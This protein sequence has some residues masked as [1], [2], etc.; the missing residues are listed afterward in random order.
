MVNSEQLKKKIDELQKECVHLQNKRDDPEGTAEDFTLEVFE[1]LGWKRRS[2]EVIRQKNVKQGPHTTRVDYSFKRENDI[3][4]SFYVE[5]KRFSDKL[6]NPEHIK[7]ALQYGKNSSTR[8]VILTNF[9]K[10]RVFNSD[11]FNE[12]DHAELFKEFTIEEVLSNEECLKWLLL[13][14]RENGECALN[15]YAKNHKKWKDSADIKEL[16]TKSLLDTRKKLCKAIF[17]QNKMKFD[18]GQDAEMEVDKCVQHIFDRIIFCRMLEDN[19]IDPNLRIKNVFDQWEEGDKRM[20]FYKDCLCPFFLKMHEKYDSTI[21]DQERIDRLS[22]KNEDFIEIFKQFYKHSNGLHYNFGAIGVDVLGHTYESYLEYNVKKT[23]K[24]TDVVEG[25]YVRKQSGIYYTPE[26][27][28]DYLVRETLGKKLAKCKTIKEALEVRVLDP[29]CGS[30]T[31]LVRAYEEFRRWLINCAKKNGA[32]DLPNQIRLNADSENGVSSFLDDVLENCIYGIDRDPRAT[33]LARLNLFLR[34]VQNPKKLP[35]L[36]I[37]ERDSL[38]S[39]KEVKN[40]FIFERDFPLVYEKGGFDVVIGNPPWEKWKPD[41]QEFFEERDPGFKSLPTQEAKKRMNELMRK[42]PYLKKEWNE[43]LAEYEAYST[44]YRENYKFQSAEAGGKMVSG[45]MDLYKIFTEQAYNLAK[46]G[47]Y[48]GFV[49]PSSIYTDLGAK[50]LRKMLFDKCNVLGLFSFENR[51]KAIFPDVHSSYKPVLL[52]FMKGSITSSFPC[53]FFLHSK[54]DLENALKKPTILTSDFV[55]KSSPTSWNILEIKSR[56]DF[57]IVQKLLKHTQLRDEIK[58]SWNI[59]TQSGFHMTNDSHLFHEGRLGGIPMLEG[60]NI[61]QFTHQWKE[62]PQAR[63]SIDEKDIYASLKDD[64]IYHKGYWLAYRLIASSTN[65]RTLIST[66]IPQGYVCGNSIAIVK[67][68]GLKNLC[69]LAGILNSFIVD[70]F[71]RQKVS[72]NVNMFYFLEIPI[73]R[74][75]SGP[76]YESIARMT[77][78][79]VSVTDEFTELKKEL[80]ISYGITNENDRLIVRAKIESEVA[81][82]YNITKQEMEY[83]LTKFPIVDEKYKKKVLDEMKS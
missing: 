70:Y 32:S 69:Y 33:R 49:V 80:G 10:W 44:Y 54:E 68:E 77:A 82:L 11:Y 67:T 71:I 64:K 26:F 29:A 14:S 66:I 63:Y 19:G 20:Q 60:K 81:K 61:H 30:G 73:P 78:Q 39:D 6:E 58:D 46:V 52:V 12:P 25:I 37:I 38:V 15:D 17:E 23:E 16:L 43:K 9:K 45:D 4:A 5:V 79:L 22:I 28:V 74:L 72:A 51:G 83:I 35:D 48:V 75:S 57:D 40:A 62:A 34:A 24:R 21:F 53:A 2:I 27:L 42:R 7:Q 3:R 55:K 36:K 13:F 59:R 76:E 65:E 56:K 41:S 8:W 1:T 47:G 31:F 50:G 18:T